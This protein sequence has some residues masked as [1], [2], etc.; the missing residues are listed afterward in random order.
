MSL[1]HPISHPDKW[2][3]AIVVLTG[4]L[5]PVG[6]AAEIPEITIIPAD[7][8]ANFGRAVASVGSNFIIGASS[9]NNKSGRAFLFDGNTGAI[10]H[11]F[12]SPDPSDNDRF[13]LSVAGSRDTVLIGS[14][15]NDTN[16]ENAGGAY[17][18][19]ADPTS[20]DFGNLIRSFLGDIGDNFG[21]AVDIFE[22]NILIVAQRDDI[23]ADDDGA[24]FIFDAVTGDLT[25]AFFNLTPEDNDRFGSS[26]AFVGNKPFV[27]AP[28]VDIGTNSSVGEAYLFDPETADLLETFV[29]PTRI[30]LIL[31]STASISRPLMARLR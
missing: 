23:G 5:L 1:I 8:G 15:F 12:S 14:F 4:L 7:E 16:G 30:H 11:V 13:G 26:V 29:N 9:D 10:L 2:L 3:N 22:S 17:L 18:Y 24:D 19:D 25:Q 31:S 6:T 27:G 20:P 28:G 21:I